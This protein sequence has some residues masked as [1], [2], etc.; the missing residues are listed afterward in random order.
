LVAGVNTHAEG[1]WLGDALVGDALGATLGDELGATVGAIRSDEHGHCAFQS[2]LDAL[3]EGGK[4]EGPSCGIGVGPG[5]PPQGDTTTANFT[6]RSSGVLGP[7]GLSGADRIQKD[8]FPT[9]ET[10]RNRGPLRTISTP[11]RA[12]SMDLQSARRSLASRVVRSAAPWPSAMTVPFVASLPM[13]PEVCS[14][15]VV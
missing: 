1:E 2:R 11:P 3:G 6:L 13:S 12:V 10:T 8:S 14:L 9:V 7:V 5:C 15:V 4:G